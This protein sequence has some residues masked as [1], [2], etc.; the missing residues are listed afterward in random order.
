MMR[1]QH[2]KSECQMTS[3]LPQLRNR[4]SSVSTSWQLGASQQTTLGW[5]LCKNQNLDR[6][7]RPL[8]N[9]RNFVILHN[10]E[11]VSTDEKFEVTRGVFCCHISRQLGQRVRLAYFWDLGGHFTELLDWDVGEPSHLGTTLDTIHRH[12]DW[13]RHRELT[14][15]HPAAVNEQLQSSP[16]TVYGPWAGLAT[17]AH[18]RQSHPTHPEQV[19]GSCRTQTGRYKATCLVF[20]QLVHFKD[21]LFASLTNLHAFY[22]LSV[23]R[24]TGYGRCAKSTWCDKARGPASCNSGQEART[25][26]RVPCV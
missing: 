14:N 20:S 6:V 4:C 16:G 24:A 8:Y 12:H 23:T 18:S 10:G 22:R 5:E 26:S 15:R 19:R 11:Q 13:I 21:D 25:V 3:T 2:G 9:N 1:R 17:S 7:G